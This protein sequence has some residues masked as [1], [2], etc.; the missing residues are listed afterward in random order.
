MSKL[1]IYDGDV[2]AA[3]NSDIDGT[4]STGATGKVKDGDN[5]SRSIV[6]WLKRWANDLGGV[7]TVGG[8]A[9]AMTVTL[10]QTAS[11]ITSGMRFQAVVATANTSTTPTL[12]I[13]PAVGS[14]F[15]AK[16]IKKYDGAGVLGAL[17]VGDNALGLREYVYLSGPDAIV[18]LNP[19]GHSVST[20]N[21][22]PL[23]GFRN[24]I[25]NGAMMV[26]Q[27]GTSFTSATTP[28]NNDD[29]YLLDRWILLSD[30]NDIVDVTQATTS[31]TNGLYSIGL[32][33]ETVN[34][35]FGI[36]QP[37]EQKNCIGLVGETVTLSFK[38]KVSATTKLDN[39][40]AA[41]ISWDGTAD[42][43]TS[44]V[45]SAWGIEGTNPTLVAN[46]TYENTP[47]NLNPTT[48]FATYSVSA[49]IDTASTKNVG[50]FI[51][52]DVTD[53][54]LGDFLYITDV[55][56]EI[57]SVA[58]PFERRGFVTEQVFAQRHCR[59]LT[60]PPLRGVVPAAA[61]SAHRMGMMLQPPMFA[62]PTATLAG[63][64]NVFD[65]SGTTTVSSLGTSYALSGSLEIDLNL[66]ADLTDGRPAILFNGSTGGTLLLVSEM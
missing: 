15:A 42:A 35:K 43:V 49:A 24:A 16:T 60:E 55:Q 57:G 23:A 28:A 10:A 21:G 50:V 66:A 32:D 64:L 6:A 17:A 39:L 34:K 47:A 7:N 38:A 29:T 45:I 26:A 25:I 41:I 54:T 33:V 53:T 4:D 31:P 8:T 48:S 63:T 44:D 9:N 19:A 62:A 12:T 58:T 3:S 51:W 18:L 2:T 1:G 56:L 13:T 27:R 65:G 14:A 22:G 52:S 11:A 46:W 59:L 20:L 30:G 37:I 5:Y 61:S 36:F 40:K